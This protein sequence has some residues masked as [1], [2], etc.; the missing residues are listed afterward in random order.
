M[1]RHAITLGGQ[2]YDHLLETYKKKNQEH[3]SKENPF[4]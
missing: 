4:I 1:Q 2:N 3:Q